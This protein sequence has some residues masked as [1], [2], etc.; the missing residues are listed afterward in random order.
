VVIQENTVRDGDTVRFVEGARSGA[1]IRRAGN[2]VEAEALVVA[3]GRVLTPGDV[4]MLATQ[5]R[6]QL[7]VV[8]APVVTVL[9]TGDEL[10]EVD[11]GAPGPGQLCNSNTIALAAAVRAA[12]GIPRVH[13]VVP[14]DRQATLDALQRGARADV[15][16]TSGGVS[17]G[18]YD[19]VGDA[20]VALSGERFDFWKVAIKPGKPLA[21]GRIGTCACF[22]L[23][24]N[25]I[26]TLVTFEVFV[27]PALLRMQGHRRILR[28][29][30]RAVL[31]APIR[32]GGTREE[33][34]R[35]SVQWRDGTLHVDPSRTQSSGALSSLCGADALV[36]HP[37]GASALASGDVVDAFLLGADDPASR[38]EHP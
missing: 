28:R 29:P 10:I 26:S 7:T 5:G 14:D 6:S 38:L 27:R 3:S 20:L 19:F 4:A 13:P 17:V 16:V 31:S 36:R 11:A 15:L 1:N 23:P 37:A 9:S 21:F 8:R 2:D 30:H 18:D 34:L 25:P 22:G 35:A 24:G 32:A 12:G 33:F